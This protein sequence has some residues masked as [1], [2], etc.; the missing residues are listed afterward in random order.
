[1]QASRSGA[2]MRRAVRLE[3]TAQRVEPRSLAGIIHHPLDPVE[4]SA[5]RQ[6]GGATTTN[7]QALSKA[8]RD[9]PILRSGAPILHEGVRRQRS[10]SVDPEGAAKV[11]ELTRG[12]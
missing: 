5:A 3:R 10:S 12:T 9:L 4:L 2:E 11:S 1:M 8:L 6:L 7:L